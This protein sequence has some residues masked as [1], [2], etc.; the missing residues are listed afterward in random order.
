[1]FTKRIREGV[2]MSLRPYAESS[3]PRLLTS[4]LVHK[5]CSYPWF[6]KASPMIYDRLR[7]SP[8]Q[9]PADFIVKKT[10]YSQFCGGENST[11]VITTMRRLKQNNILPILDYAAESGSDDPAD[12][13]QRQP[14]LNSIQQALQW[15][16]LPEFEGSRLALKLSAFFPYHVLRNLSEKIIPNDLQFS[17][18][19]LSNLLQSDEDIKSMHNDLCEFVEKSAKNNVTVMIDAERL[20]TQPAIDFIALGL[21][22]KFNLKKRIAVQNTYQMYEKNALLRMKAHYGYALANKFNFGAKVVRGAYLN[23]D[24]DVKLSEHYGPLNSRLEDTHQQYNEVIKLIDSQW[25]QSKKIM[26][27]ITL[28]THNK[29]SLEL[30]G[31]LSGSAKSGSVS[32]AQLLGMQDILTLQCVNMGLKTYKYVP[33]G[34]LKLTIPYL[35]RR[36]VENMDATRNVEETAM[37][38]EEI[39]LRL[40]GQK[41][42]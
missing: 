20:D 36:A 13:L 8:F 11:E 21:M 24:R 17:R 33:F 14:V 26:I 30:A 32:C 31:Q 19:V 1:M 4:Y 7:H 35:S 34:P 9:I 37:V 23:Q 10:F 15:A 6:V 3:W 18:D 22:E 28:A 5:S 29:K 16:S 12:T 40:F 27:D 41:Q 39:R 2:I 38:L 42:K 25:T